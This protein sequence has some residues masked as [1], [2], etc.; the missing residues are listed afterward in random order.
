MLAIDSGVQGSAATLTPAVLQAAAMLG[1]YHA[2]LARV[3]H[4]LCG[5]VGLLANARKRLEPDTT[6]WQQA[7]LFL[8]FYRAI[9][10]W[11]KG[12]RI[13]SWHWLRTHNRELDG[14]PLLLIID[15][16]QLARVLQHVLQRLARQD[17]QGETGP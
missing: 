13:A 6:S 1:L 8:R 12:D 9:Y 10:R 17:N 5:E 7:V 16:D 2:E 14:V 4:M 15:D 3:L 11:K